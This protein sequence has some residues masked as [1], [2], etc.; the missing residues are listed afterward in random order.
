MRRLGLAAGAG[1]IAVGAIVVVLLG[2][3]LSQYHL[4][5]VATV[6]VYLIALLGLDVVT[7]WTGQVSLGHSAFMLLGGYTTAILAGKHGVNELATIPLAALVA[8]AVGLAFGLPALRL[9]GLYLALATFAFAVAAPQ[10]LRWSLIESTTGGNSGILLPLKSNVWYFRLGWI[11]A[12]I[13]FVVAWLVLRARVGRTFLAIRDSEV[14]A[15][16][17]GVP[18]GRYKALAWAWSGAYGGVAGSLLVIL[19]GFANPAEF[20][21]TLSLI[22]LVGLVVSGFASVW[23]LV[24]GALFVEFLPSIV[25]SAVAHLPVGDRLAKSGLG[26][27]E[28]AVLILV[29]F[30]L[31]GGAA[32]LLRR[33]GL[34]T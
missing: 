17:S 11:C 18:A 9:S 3:R 12:G 29:M 26:V 23:G 31:P 15:A 22:L 25:S 7:G 1:A 21:F 14:A 8:G 20:A 13:L 34:R 28:G 5:E 30:L 16:S 4:Y 27:V 19:A 6:A 32:G 2:T 24:L 33:A 10:F